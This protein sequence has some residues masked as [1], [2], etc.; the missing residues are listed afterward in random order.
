VKK[1]AIAIIMLFTFGCASAGPKYTWKIEPFSQKVENEYF[2]ASIS[3]T[4]FDY[5]WNGYEA[6][7][8]T[9]KNKTGLDIELDWN[10]TIYIENNQ[11]KGGFMFEGVVYKD[12]NNPKPPDI[13]FAGADFKKTIWPNT[14]V[15]FYRSWSHEII[16]PGQNGVYIT[17]KTNENEIKEKIILNM[18]KVLMQDIQSQPLGVAKYDDW[19]GIGVDDSIGFVRVVTVNSGGAAF[20]TIL[21]GDIILEINRKRI[22]NVPEYIAAME[23]LKGSSVLYLISRG[24]NSYYVVVKPK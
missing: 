9:V 21:Q 11:T 7:E 17:I 8:L 6:F 16:P 23:K 1:F 22:R 20:S 19:A 4:A 3:P 10:K 18:S 2:S 5:T 15:S 14:L 24:V 12:R 13:I